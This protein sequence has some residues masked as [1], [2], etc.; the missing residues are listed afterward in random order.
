M[1]KQMLKLSRQVHAAVE[2]HGLD[3]GV[4]L[5][6]NA[7]VREAEATERAVQRRAATYAANA[8]KRAAA[9]AQA[10]AA[11]A[12]QVRN[13]ACPRCFATHAGEC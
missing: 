5:L 13:A 7:M 9:Q 6:W 12:A 3:A 10:N 11:E 2:A 4:R 1:D 8:P